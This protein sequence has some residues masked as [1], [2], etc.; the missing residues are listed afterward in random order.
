MS[1]HAESPDQDGPGAE[2]TPPSSPPPAPTEPSP[3]ARKAGRV[4]ARSLGKAKAAMASPAVRA[5]GKKAASAAASRYSASAQGQAARMLRNKDR[6]LS[7]AR[8]GDDVVGDMESGALSGFGDEFRT[9]L[10][11]IRAYATGE[12]RDVPFETMVPVVAA[13]VYVVSPIDL[14]PEFIPG[15]GGLDDLT[16]ITY[17]LRNVR[18]QLDKFIAWE[19]ETGRFP[20]PPLPPVSDPDPTTD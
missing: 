13:I 2:A 14:I 6:L 3:A 7:L 9:L 8:R 4:F 19:R 12:Y 11:L 15:V 17:A 16:V 10:R 18:D 1:T 5:A 20:H